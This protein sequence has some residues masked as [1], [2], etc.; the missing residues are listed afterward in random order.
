[1]SQ[2]PWPRLLAKAILCPSGDHAG[3][4]SIAEFVVSRMTSVPSLSITKISTLPARVLEKT[5]LSPPGDH[6][7]SASIAGP[8]VSRAQ[9]SPPAGSTT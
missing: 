4:V 7:G 5:I 3:D 1:M 2:L 6:S 9:V 8:V